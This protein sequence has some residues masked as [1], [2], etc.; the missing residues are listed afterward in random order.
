MAEINDC[1]YTCSSRILVRRLTGIYRDRRTLLYFLYSSLR[2][3]RLKYGNQFCN[4]L[5]SP[6]DLCGLQKLL[7]ARERARRA[8]PQQTRTVSLLVKSWPDRLMLEWRQRIASQVVEHYRCRELEIILLHQVQSF[9]NCAFLIV[10]IIY[11]LHPHEY[12][13]AIRKLNF[14]DDLVH[15]SRICNLTCTPSRL[16]RF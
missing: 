14:A 2:W 1:R 11:K 6:S 3:Q 10:L 9:V 7:A 13:T 15:F 16:A 4:R 8:P 5:C 12:Y